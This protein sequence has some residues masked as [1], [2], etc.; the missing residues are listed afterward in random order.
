[1]NKNFGGS[2]D[3]AVEKSAPKLKPGR[4]FFYFFASIVK[5]QTSVIVDYDKRSL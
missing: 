1:M 4:G 2:I 5:T 3:A